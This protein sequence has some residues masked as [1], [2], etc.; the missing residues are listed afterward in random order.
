[1]RGSLNLISLRSQKDRVGE[2]WGEGS[3]L[4]KDPALSSRM[5]F[6]GDMHLKKRAWWAAAG[7]L[8]DESPLR[9]VSTL[10]AVLADLSTLKVMPI[11][12]VFLFATAI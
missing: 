2:L 4:P 12:Q 9:F 8:D 5:L 10:Q 7:S 1:M 6:C 11:I 3:S